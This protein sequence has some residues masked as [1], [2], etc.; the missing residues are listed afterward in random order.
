MKIT[1]FLAFAFT[2]QHSKHKPAVAFEALSIKH[3]KKGEVK[4]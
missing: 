2:F 4:H 3:C 1:G